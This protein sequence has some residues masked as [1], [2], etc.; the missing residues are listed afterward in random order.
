MSEVKENVPPSAEFVNAFIHSGSL[1][2][3]CELCGR[4]HFACY[5]KGWYEEGELERLRK[6]AAENPDKYIEDDSSDSIGWGTI[7]GKQFV[8]DCPC[9][10]ETMRRYE[11]FVVECRYAILK[12]LRARATRLQKRAEYEVEAVSG[13][14]EEEF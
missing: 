5:E 11:D 9:L 8:W 3:S 12:Y 1:V 13:V 2:I 6:K 7:A 14:S 4:E 10:P